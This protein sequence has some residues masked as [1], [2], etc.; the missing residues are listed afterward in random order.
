LTGNASTATT[1]ATSRTL[2]GQSF[3]GSGNVTGALTSVGDITGTAAVTLAS[4]NDRLTLSAGGANKISFLTNGSERWLISSAGILEAS[5]AQT[6][7]TATGTLTIGTAAGNGNIIL[8]PHGTGIVVKVTGTNSAG[9][10]LGS[11]T[12]GSQALL[13]SNALYGMYSGVSNSGDVWHQVQRNDTNTAAYGMLLQPN[14]GGVAIAKGTTSP[15]FQLD[16]TGTGNATTDFRAPIFYDS[17]NTGYN[18]N[19]AATSNLW[20]LTFSYTFKLLKLSTYMN[21]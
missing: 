12:V 16:I 9:P 2:W 10:T 11:G 19:P 3:N 5:G 14:G 4:T 7:R 18:V 1:L 6:L 20:I 8:S 21:S 13:A 15:A 17:D